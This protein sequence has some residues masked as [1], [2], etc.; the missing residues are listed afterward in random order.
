MTA[1]HAGKGGVSPLSL[2]VVVSSVFNLIVAILRF[3]CM[4]NKLSF[5]ARCTC[6]NVN[7]NRV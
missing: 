6:G 3:D 4:S 7:T 2:Y 5:N 1:L